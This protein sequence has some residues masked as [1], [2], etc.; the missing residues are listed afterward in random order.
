MVDGQISFVNGVLPLLKRRRS[1]STMSGLSV[2]YQSGYS[3]MARSAERV[4][5]GLA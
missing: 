4:Y 3:V 1:Q 2:S 5:R